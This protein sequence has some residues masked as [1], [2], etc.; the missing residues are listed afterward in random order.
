C[1][2]IIQLSQGIVV[3]QSTVLNGNGHAVTILGRAS[4]GIF[5][6]SQG[7]TFSVIGLNISDGGG[8]VST[9]NF[10]DFV[11]RGGGIRNEG[12]TLNVINC[13]MTNNTTRGRGG[14]IYNAG[15]LN[16]TNSLFADNRVL[17]VGVGG[18]FNSYGEP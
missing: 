9:T 17:A 16:V 5:D 14:A 2:G 1:D 12:G 18:P 4:V 11:F 15:M 3:S 13:V 6:V 8:W 7:V 10:F